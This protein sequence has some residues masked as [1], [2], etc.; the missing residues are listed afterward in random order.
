MKNYKAS[1][2][3]S[4][5]SWCIYKNIDTELQFSDSF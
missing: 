2:L 5:L 3:D 1:K 4:F